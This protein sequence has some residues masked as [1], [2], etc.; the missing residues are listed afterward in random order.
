MKSVWLGLGSNIGDRA[1]YLRR[2]VEL[3]H[4]P[5]LKVLRVSPVYETA[6]QGFLDQ[7]WFLN[8]VLEAET[9][10]LP[11][12]LL[13][14]CGR[15]ERE[16]GRRRSV[17]NGP[18]TIDIDILFYANAVIRGAR[19]DTPHPRYSERRFVLQPLADLDPGHR[20]PVT[21]KTAGELLG[22]VAGQPIRRTAI[23]IG[24]PAT[25]SAPPAP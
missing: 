16:L 13:A 22:A 20:D 15:I 8:L 23:S 19:L 14:R 12:R 24:P 3:L 1:T 11:L 10:L 5:A 9:S 4:A 17:P 25:A 2:A 6:P 21:R 18:R 7:N